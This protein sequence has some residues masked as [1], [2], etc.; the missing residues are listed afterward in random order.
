MQKLTVLALAMSGFAHASEEGS[1]GLTTAAPILWEIDLPFWPGHSLPI[2]NSLFMFAL[3]ALA[4]TILLRLAT[5]KME[6][7]PH[8]LQ[9]FVEWVFES[10]YN[11]VEGLV[12]KYLA[13]KYFWYFASVFLLIL[14]SNYMGLLPG[15]GEITYD[16][17]PLLRGANADMG[18]TVFL[19]FF[20]ALL[21]FI[22]VMIEQG[23]WRFL[24]HTFGPK[25]GLT[26]FMKYIL[27]PIFFFVG[28]IE[29]L[30]FCIR[31]VAL[32]AR[33]FGNIFAGESILE[34]MGEIG[35]YAMVPFMGLELIVGFV[36][37]L[38]F[39]M[40]TALFL[41]SQ[42]DDEEEEEQHNPL[43]PKPDHAAKT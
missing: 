19:G 39:L 2:S 34:K 16:G 23:P 38:V 33:L 12:G 15:V 1:E 42:V 22:W 5:R 37:A 20:Y 13:R 3:A 40:L 27:L 24:T 7:I 9:N 8:G 36:Q 43:P 41:K 31:P 17:K 26:G 25:G 28:L 30:S 4:I 29:I 14:T 18:V 21:W 35:W 10:L 11:F 6:R 32:S